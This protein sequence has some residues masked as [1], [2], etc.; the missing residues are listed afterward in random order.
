MDFKFSEFYKTQFDTV[1]AINLH[2]VE[3]NKTG[4]HQRFGQYL[5]SK[6]PTL[7]LP[8]CLYESV[9]SYEPY[10]FVISMIDD[11]EFVGDI[12]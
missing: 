2:L 11:D 3:W 5:V 10:S 12:K 9:D 1:H 8:Q 4:R 7:M 6:Y